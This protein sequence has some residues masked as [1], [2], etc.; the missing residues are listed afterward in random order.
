MGSPCCR[1]GRAPW[2][3]PGRWSHWTTRGTIADDSS[4][5]PK[6]SDG[7]KTDGTHGDL[8]VTTGDSWVIFTSRIWAFPYVSIDGGTLEIDGD[9][10]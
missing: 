3:S 5:K 1:A 8:M 10:W 9:L 6:R 7:V 2:R 4:S